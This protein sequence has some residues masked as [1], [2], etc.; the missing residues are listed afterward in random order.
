MSLS[1]KKR[2]AKVRFSNHCDGITARFSIFHAKLIRYLDHYCF[3]MA[4]GQVKKRGRY[5]SLK[6]IK[7][8][9][10]HME[11]NLLYGKT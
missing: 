5:F 1:T 2:R 11:E 6:K 3:G 8:S 4:L 9:I 7:K 10:H